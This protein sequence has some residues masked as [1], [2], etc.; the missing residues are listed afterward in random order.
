M[1]NSMQLM[2]GGRKSG[3]AVR[4]TTHLYL[5]PKLPIRDLYN[6]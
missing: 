1:T 4:L 5:V 6:R 2:N 3:M